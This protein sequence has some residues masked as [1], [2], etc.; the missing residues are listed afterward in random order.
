MILE[1]PHAA[2]IVAIKLLEPDGCRVLRPFVRDIPV[3]H[4]PAS[5]PATARIAS[6]VA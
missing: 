6:S 3:L 2:S 4:Y 5:A 1:F